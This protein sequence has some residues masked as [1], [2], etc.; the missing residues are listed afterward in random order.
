MSNIEQAI[1]VGLICL[2]VGIALRLIEVRQVNKSDR[3][4]GV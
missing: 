2:A 1:C 4:K 3:R